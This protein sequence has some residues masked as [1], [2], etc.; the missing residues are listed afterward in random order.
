MRKKFMR[1]SSAKGFAEKVGT[2][3]TNVR[4]ESNCD[5]NYVVHYKSRTQKKQDDDSDLNDDDSDLNDDSNHISDEHCGQDSE[6]N[7]SEWIN[8]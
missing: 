5:A 3:V 6:W 2:H 1:E 7:G 4:N 8:W